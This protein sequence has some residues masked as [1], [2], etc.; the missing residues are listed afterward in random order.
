MQLV[1]QAVVLHE[2]VDQGALAAVRA[3]A[4]EGQE[5]RMAD[6]AQD[7]H[8]R[9]ELLLALHQVERTSCLEIQMTKC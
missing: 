4:D 2:R 8:L 1:E 3:I 5:V 7:V 6:P 9:A